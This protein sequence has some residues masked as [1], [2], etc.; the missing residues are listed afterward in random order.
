MDKPWY[1]VVVHDHDDNGHHYI[2]AFH[3]VWFPFDGLFRRTSWP[4]VGLLSCERALQA[5]LFA[6]SEAVFHAAC[7]LQRM[8]VYRQGE[9]P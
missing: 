8:M 7:I 5:C 6:H 2:S 4:V 9:T 1:E 3:C